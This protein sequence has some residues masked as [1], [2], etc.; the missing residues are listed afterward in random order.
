MVNGETNY[1]HLFF[2][3]CYFYLSLTAGDTHNIDEAFALMREHGVVD[4]DG[5]E[6]ERWLDNGGN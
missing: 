1:K 5:F 6:I 3:M 4:E 2:R